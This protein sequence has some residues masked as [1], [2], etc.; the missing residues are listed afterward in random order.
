VRQGVR[1]FVKPNAFVNQLQWSSHHTWLLLAFLI[2]AGVE[3][4]VGRNHQLI[5]QFAEALA[6]RLGVNHEIGMW[7]VISAKLICTLAAATLI[8]FLVWIVGSFIGESSSQ[9]VL[10]RRLS[11]VFTLVLAAYTS[12]HLTHVYP[13]METAALFGYFWAA[14]L[15]FFTLREQFRIGYLETFFVGGL[16]VLLVLS[17]WHFS[18][19]YIEKNAHT[20]SQ[21]IAYHPL[22]FSQGR[23]SK[24]NSK[25]VR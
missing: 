9:R 11:V 25:S 13:W 20:I 22:P 21:E 6:S 10:F 1:F 23:A 4:H 14:L 17:T 7:L 16:T 8:S 24:S 15:G 12:S 18:N 2:I 5:S 19:R 3:A